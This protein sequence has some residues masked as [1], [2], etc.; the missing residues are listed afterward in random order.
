MIDFD[1][2]LGAQIINFLVL[3]YLLNVVLFRP[4][5]K[6]LKERQERLQ[7]YEAAAAQLAEQSQGI[8]GEIQEKLTV[9]R[10]E[11]L[12]QKE[13]LRQAGAQAEAS[14]LEKVKQE[15]DAEWTRVEKKIKEDIDKARKSL[16][17]QA[18]SFAQVMAAK[19]LG[20]E[21]S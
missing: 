9:A 15:V 10:R 12:G 3:V 13:G 16:K 18:Q 14:L 11:G 8:A 19:I 17:T 21:L 1:W 5:R 4:I 2:T 7:A 20:R 6:S